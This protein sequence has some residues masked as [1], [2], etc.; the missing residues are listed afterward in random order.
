[1]I[2]SGRP[3]L[4]PGQASDMHEHVYRKT[5][6]RRDEYIGD[7]TFLEPRA[8]AGARCIVKKDSSAFCD[9]LKNRCWA[10][11]IRDWRSGIVGGVHPSWG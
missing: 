11:G 10:S 8:A 9:D 5:R 3:K 6:S 4:V 2:S 7:P 1:V